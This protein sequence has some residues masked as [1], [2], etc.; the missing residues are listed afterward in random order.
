[1]SCGARGSANPP[2]LVSLLAALLSGQVVQAVQRER[3]EAVAR[4]LNVR[5]PTAQQGV[6][7]LPA[8][9][10]EDKA[11]SVQKQIS[12]QQSR[13]VTLPL[14]SQAKFSRKDCAGFLV[15]LRFP[16]AGSGEAGDAG[17]LPQQEACEPALKCSRLHGSMT[18]PVKSLH[19][20]SSTN[21]LPGL[22]IL[23]STRC[24]LRHRRLRLF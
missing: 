17:L 12:A 19:A 4:P 5:A 3:L 1:M 20:A 11:A 15:W 24:W 16:A 23:Q 8:V 6:V 10:L 18:H 22:L 14:V 9:T 7:P 2:E 13:Q 21:S